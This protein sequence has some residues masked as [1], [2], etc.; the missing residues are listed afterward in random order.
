MASIRRGTK[1]FSVKG[2]KI[3]KIKAPKMG[4]EDFSKP[5]KA[6]KLSEGTIGAKVRQTKGDLDV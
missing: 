1:N 5:I 3:P 6:P 2:S 4:T